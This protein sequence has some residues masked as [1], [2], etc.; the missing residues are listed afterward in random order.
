MR[1]KHACRALF[2]V[3]FL[4]DEGS[5]V[6]L[7]LTQETGLGEMC[8]WHGVVGEDK[9]IYPGMSADLKAQGIALCHHG[10]YM[11]NMML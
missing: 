3:V 6:G 8:G 1:R 11:S 4:P 7:G 10:N 2:C 5:T 9:A